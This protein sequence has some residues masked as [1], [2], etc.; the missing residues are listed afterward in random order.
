M[1]GSTAIVVGALPI[2]PTARAA[3]DCKNF[4][5]VFDIKPLFF[6]SVPEFVK[7]LNRN[8]SYDKPKNGAP[9][10]TG[11]CSGSRR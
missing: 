8:L 5:R 11:A 3:L 1:A 9:F 7:Y 10:S 6:L 4:R 2:M